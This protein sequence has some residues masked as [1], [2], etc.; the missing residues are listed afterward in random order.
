MTLN[1]QVPVNVSTQT[2][3]KLTMWYE[4]GQISYKSI[5]NDGI[6]KTTTWDENGQKTH[7]ATYKDGECISGDAVLNKN[8]KT[9]HTSIRLI[10][11]CR[12][13]KSHSKNYTFS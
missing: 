5:Y 10:L 6:S 7:V 11:L 1:S 9:T 13:I 8:E 12:I 2:L 4:N 3:V